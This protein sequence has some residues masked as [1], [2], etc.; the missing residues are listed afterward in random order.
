MLD[1]VEH[2]ESFGNGML[3]CVGRARMEGPAAAAVKGPTRAPRDGLA[4]DPVPRKRET[5][6]VQPVRQ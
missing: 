6:F 3:A 4:Q 5:V 2:H 1:A